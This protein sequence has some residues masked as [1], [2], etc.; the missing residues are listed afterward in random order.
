MMIS[1]TSGP[2]NLFLLFLFLLFLLLL[3]LLLLHLSFLIARPRRNGA[4]D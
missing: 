2:V 4:R 3:F 1:I